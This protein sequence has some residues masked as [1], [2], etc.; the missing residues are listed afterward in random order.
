MEINVNVDAEAINK[1]IT[2]AV[3]K[4]AIGKEIKRVIEEKVKELST[5]Y[6][7][8]LSRVVGREIEKMLRQLIEEEYMG[9]IKEFVRKQMSDDFVKDILGKMWK[10]YLES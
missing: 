10:A 1:E 9:Q 5:S 2:E 7:N 4:S 6:N 3:A 8:P